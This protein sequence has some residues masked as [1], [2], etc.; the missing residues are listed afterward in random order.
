VLCTSSMSFIAFLTEIHFDM[1]YC[2]C[3]V[4]MLEFGTGTALKDLC[5]QV[6]SAPVIVQC[7][8][9]NWKYWGG[10]G[11]LEESGMVT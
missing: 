4:Q 10:G 3:Q 11:Q 7:F 5:S 9:L 1:I 6:S 8:I 2:I